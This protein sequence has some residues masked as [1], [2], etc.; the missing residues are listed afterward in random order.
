MNII[1]INRKESFSSKHLEKLSQAGT[2]IFIETENYQN[3]PA[4]QTTEDTILAV[5]PEVTKWQLP[6]KTFDALSNVKAVC[7]PTTSYS[8]VDGQFLRSKNISLSNVPH[9][10]TESVAEYAISLMLNLTKKLPLIIQNNWTFDRSLHKGWEIKGKTMGVIGLGTIGK[11]IAQLGQAMGMRVLYW[12]KSSRDNSFTYTEL[13]SL[14]ANADYIFPVLARTEQTNKI[15]NKEKLNRI[16]KGG[17]L[18]SVTGEELFDVEHAISLVQSSIL[19]GLAFE[20]DK[21]T[22]NNTQ[23]KNLIGNIFISP[24]IAWYTYEASGQNIDMWTENI[25]TATNGKPLNVVN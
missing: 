9:Y 17:F 14:L 7:I 16:K 1:V 2:L 8:W 19:N 10:S 4:L 23:F 13:D 5:G 25:L 3:H 18:V 24:P 6:N 15:L 12:S 11:R 21:Y 20:T 22:V